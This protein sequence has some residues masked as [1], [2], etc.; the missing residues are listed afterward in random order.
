MKRK[1]FRQTLKFKHQHRI[2]EYTHGDRHT[3]TYTY[4]QTYNTDNTYKKIKTEHKTK[5]KKT[6]QIAFYYLSTTS[7]PK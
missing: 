2:K 3:H 5:H 4:I 6:E 7:I 1:I